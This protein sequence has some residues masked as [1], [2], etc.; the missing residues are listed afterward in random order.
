MIVVR[1]RLYFPLGLGLLILYLFYT[2]SRR[3]G[4]TPVRWPPL[5]S[6]GMGG[7]TP[8][9]KVLDDEDYF[10]RRRPEH[11]PVDSMRPLPTEKPLGLPQVQADFDKELDD[12]RDERLSRRATVKDAFKRCWETYKK[13]AWLQDEVAPISG[14]SRNPFGGWGATLVDSLDTLWIMGLKREFEEAVRAT[15]NISFETSS[16]T[17]VNTFETTIRYLGGF[18]SAYDLSGDARLLQKARE[19]GDMLYAAFDT[20]NRMPITRWNIEKAAKGERQEASSWAPLAEMGSLCLEFTRLSLVTGNPKW[21]DASERVML[22]LQA[23]QMDTQL[24]GLWPLTLNPKDLKFTDDNTFGMGAMGDSVYEYLPKMVALMGGTLPHYEDM[25]RKATATALKYNIFRPMVPDAADILVTGQ[26]RTFTSGSRVNRLVEH[27]G[28]HL[29]CF[30]G[31]MFALGGKLLDMPDHMKTARKLVDGCTW[32]YRH[33]PLGIMPEAFSM[34]PCN[35][36]LSCSWDEKKWKRAVMERAGESPVSDYDR[37]EQVISDRRLPEGFTEI[38]DGRYMLRPE[39]IEALFVMYRTTA[40]AQ[41]AD[42]AWSMFA[43]IQATT[44]T[45]LANSA[46]KD[47]SVGSPIDVVM[48]DDME[49]FWMGETLKYF[50]L[51]FSEP[52]FLSLDE[53]VF[54]TEAHPFR[55]L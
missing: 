41:L 9:P 52:D 31:G 6:L 24:P 13:R 38:S 47:V 50:Y 10:W 11:F 53:W 32:A 40:D 36:K 39:G 55:R 27:Q 33:M 17:E 51:I 2:L 18:L 22:A 5:E 48:S 8:D 19:V 30:V 12:D 4:S 15:A 1:R 23:Q 46:I 3:E 37:A 54:S 45:D 29:T 34:A 16:L 25:Y 21:F 42:H 43:A 7:W 28:Q 14:E 20:P 44:L 35:S 49:S 26:V